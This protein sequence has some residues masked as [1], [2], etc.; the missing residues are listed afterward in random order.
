MDIRDIPFEVIDISSFEALGAPLRLADGSLDWT[1]RIPPGVPERDH[2]PDLPPWLLE[3]GDQRIGRFT[4]SLDLNLHAP[5]VAAASLDRLSALLARLDTLDATI[6]QAVVSG[7][8]TLPLLK[9]YL[10]PGLFQG[11]ESPYLATLFPGCASAELVSPDAFFD[12]LTFCRLGYYDRAEDGAGVGQEF[13]IA[14]Y[15]FLVPELIA[16]D[17]A[18]RDDFVMFGGLHD[19]TNQV[20][21]AKARL[22]GSVIDISIES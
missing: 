9:T 19:I 3:A 22:D 16:S 11:L 14:D 20:V 12:S 17:A 1:D 10:L 13:V 7:F 21:T 6:R 5:R 8:D 4:L 2:G 18:R 15:R